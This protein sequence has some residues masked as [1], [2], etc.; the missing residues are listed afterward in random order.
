MH[1]DWG[2]SVIDGAAAERPSSTEPP[3]LRLVRPKDGPTLSV[4]LATQKPRAE[5]SDALPS[6]ALMCAQL[7]A[8]L[9]VIGADAHPPLGRPLS[10]HVRYVAAP[11]DASTSQMRELAMAQCMGDI[12]VLLDDAVASHRSWVERVR[13]ASRRIGERS[14]D[15]LG[16]AARSSVDWGSYFSSAR[17]LGD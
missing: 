2:T 1:L 9:L 7:G 14:A 3:A 15:E 17:A 13:A 10:R 16:H 8:E 4:V 12:V 5:L 6:L 11:A